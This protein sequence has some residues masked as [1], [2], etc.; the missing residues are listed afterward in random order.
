MTQQQK[1]HW[2]IPKYRN[3]SFREVQA[4]FVEKLTARLDHLESKETFI[5]GLVRFLRKLFV[6]DFFRGRV[7]SDLLQRVHLL[8]AQAP[9]WDGSSN[10]FGV[11]AGGY[12]EGKGEGAIAILLVD[13]ENIGLTVE[14][15][16][17]LQSICQFPIQI[18]IAFANWRNSN[19]S[20]RDLVLHKRGY[21]LVHVPSGKN[22]ADLQ[23]TAIGSSVFVH[24][25]TAKEIIICSSDP[26][27]NHLSNILRTRGLA[28]YSVVKQGKSLVI[29]N[30][31]TGAVETHFPTGSG[32]SSGY[33][34]EQEITRILKD[35]TDPLPGTYISISTLSTQF[36]QLHGQ[37][38]TE[39]MKDLNLGSKYIKFLQ[40]CS[41]LKLR[42]TDNGWQVSLCNDLFDA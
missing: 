10:I 35:L 4:D 2:L 15:E 1:P 11:S 28:V 29:S 36:K 34:L 6:P 7:F 27:L 33:A 41:D 17:F 37:S 21:Q 9:L 25:P 14:G 26:D 38:V 31:T 8:L 12:E 24:Y 23:M 13:A 3:F 18:K 39:V 16:K 19:M 30:Y 42:L 22:S 5:F 32:V 20:K 40:T